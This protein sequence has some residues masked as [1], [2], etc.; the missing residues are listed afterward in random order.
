MLNDLGIKMTLET[1]LQATEH[2]F[3]PQTLAYDI[4]SHTTKTI[5]HNTETILF[6]SRQTLLIHLSIHM[7]EILCTPIWTELRSVLPDICSCSQE[8]NPTSTLAQIFIGF[9]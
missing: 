3:S 8:S 5:L 1:K 9:S 7:L 2:S 6:H 4:I